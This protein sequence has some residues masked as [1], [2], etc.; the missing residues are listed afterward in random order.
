MELKARDQ[1]EQLNSHPQN[2]KFQ[3]K[4][5]LYRIARVDNVLHQLKVTILMQFHLNQ[6]YDLVIMLELQVIV[7]IYLFKKGEREREKKI[8]RRGKVVILS[9][10]PTVSGNA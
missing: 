3:L 7:F 6:I 4:F 2:Q 1:L 10:V 8:V 5:G 9:K